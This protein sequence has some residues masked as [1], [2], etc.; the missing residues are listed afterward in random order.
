M[1]TC[2]TELCKSERKVFCRH[3]KAILCY[4][5]KDK[6][7]RE[8]EVEEIIIPARIDDNITHL[9]K[10]LDIMKED[11]QKLKIQMHIDGIDEFIPEYHSKTIKMKEHLA[12]SI[13]HDKFLEYGDLLKSILELSERILENEV[14]AS[15]C[16]FM[17][18]FNTTHKVHK[19]KELE[20]GEEIV[21]PEE[22]QI[23]EENKKATEKYLKKICEGR[24]LEKLYEEV[25]KCDLKSKRLDELK[26]DL[27]IAKDVE[28]MNA[29]IKDNVTIKDLKCLTIQDCDKNISEVSRFLK[30]QFFTNIFKLELS[31]DRDCKWS[32]CELKTI[33]SFLKTAIQKMGSKEVCLDVW[34]IGS[35]DF[36]VLLEGCTKCETLS[37]QRGCFKISNSIKLDK[38]ADFSIK[39]LKLSCFDNYSLPPKNYESILLGI[40]ESKL[41]DSIKE[42]RLGQH[43]SQNLSKMKSKA[44][45]LGLEHIKFL[46]MT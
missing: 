20:L 2:F 10:M 13:K 44:K 12:N 15:Y 7:H 11:S 8:C 4:G 22:P 25:M 35:S 21:N 9:L 46:R 43:L 37:I 34:K 31:C 6:Y 45:P 36:S 16:S 40:K 3:H 32:S 14:Y 1:K 28:F 17:M 38:N 19:L 23:M 33:A 18:N 42:I 29:I 30:H 5:C 24:E 26:I 39:T 41:Q 27:S